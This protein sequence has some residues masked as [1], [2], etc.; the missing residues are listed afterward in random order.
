MTAPWC[1]VQK[2]PETK[3]IS[4]VSTVLKVS[5]YVSDCSIQFV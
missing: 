5:A 3:E 1:S 4:V 2:D